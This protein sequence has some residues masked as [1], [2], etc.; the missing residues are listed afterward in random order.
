MPSAFLDG[1]Q[2]SFYSD[3]SFAR[4]GTAVGAFHRRGHTSQILA[5][6]G[7][8]LLCRRV[9]PVVAPTAVLGGFCFV[10]LGLS[11]HA[12]ERHSGR[13]KLLSHWP[14]LCML[15][16]FPIFVATKLDQAYQ[17]VLTHK[18]AFCLDT[19][20]IPFPPRPFSI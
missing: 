19:I 16:Q 1:Q 15:L 6:S 5:I 20:G 10:V 8:F 14:A 9:V 12:G 2:H 18:F 13:W 17:Q 3:Q 7:K 11:A 4:A